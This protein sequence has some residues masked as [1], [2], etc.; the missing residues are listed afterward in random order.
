VFDPDFSEL[1][2]PIRTRARSGDKLARFMPG[3]E[4]VVTF[5]GCP[6]G[7]AGR[8]VLDA[9]CDDPSLAWQRDRSGLPL[10]SVKKRRGCDL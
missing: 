6:W 10:R 1:R 2:C 3:I 5:G 4:T 7:R 9:R 8:Q